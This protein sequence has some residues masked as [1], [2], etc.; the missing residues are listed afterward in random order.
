MSPA[1]QPSDTPESPDSA[2]LP[3]IEESIEVS[4]TPAQVWSVVTDFGRMG[5]WSPQVVRTFVQGGPVKLGTRAININRDR[6]L[7]WPTRSKVI[8]FDP[9]REFAFR[10]KDNLTIWSFTL[11]PTEAGTRIVQRREAPDGTSSIS[12]V[13]VD[14]VL[15]GQEGFQGKLRTGMRQTLERIKADVER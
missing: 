3:L 11:E 13:L 5:E 15:G 4:A 1:E 9:H 10:V 6:F 8:R 7:F 14:K 2:V 12:S